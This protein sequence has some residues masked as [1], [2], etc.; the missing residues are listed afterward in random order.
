MFLAVRYLTPQLLPFVISANGSHS[1]RFFGDRVIESRV[2]VQ[3]G[4]PLGSALFY[5]AIHLV[6][7]DP[8]SKLCISY[9]DDITIGGYWED[10]VHDFQR[11]ELLAQD[12]SL[13]LNLNK[14]EV[15]CRDHTTLGS[16]LLNI[17]GLMV[18]NPQSHTP[19][20][21]HPFCC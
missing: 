16:L 19:F 13:S 18:V 21:V 10:I 7:K 1:S 15:I 17:P 8:Q 9:L 2:G 12:V 20:W 5:L 4:D 3:Q 11:M 6:I 14:C